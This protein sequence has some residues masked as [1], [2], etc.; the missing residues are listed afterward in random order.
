MR[1]IGRTLGRLHDPA[2]AALSAAYV[3]PTWRIGFSSSCRQSYQF[4]RYGAAAAAG[5]PKDDKRERASV[6]F[7]RQNQDRMCAGAINATKYRSARGRKHLVS[8][9]KVGARG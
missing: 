2:L 9:G 8:S 4:G 5:Q 7:F 1:T 3:V 6:R